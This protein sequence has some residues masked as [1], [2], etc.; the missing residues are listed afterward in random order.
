MDELTNTSC[1]D[2][3]LKATCCAQLT[4]SEIIVQTEERTEAAS[5][6]GK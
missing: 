6:T 1:G 4:S 2:I 3:W 5:F